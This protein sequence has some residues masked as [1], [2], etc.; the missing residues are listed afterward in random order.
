MRTAAIVVAML[1]MACPGK[2]GPATPAEPVSH[3]SAEIVEAATQLV[4]QWRQAW[5]VRSP[6]ALKALYAHDVDVVIVSQGRANLGWTAV[7]AWIDA[8]LG[9]ATSIH[10]TVEGLSIGALGTGAAS[11][12][13]TL[14]R[15]I[16]DGVSAAMENGQVTMALRADG[17]T[18]LIVAE[19]Y[20][21]PST[22]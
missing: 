3:T 15:E 2:S 16:N 11:L 4:E 9:R 12:V 1:L 22:M 18:W 8:E 21:F 19:H 7:E 10:L 17:D 5:E 13:C 14:R 20:S 6:D